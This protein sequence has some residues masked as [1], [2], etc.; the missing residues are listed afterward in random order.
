MNL[1]SRIFVTCERRSEL[2][3][4]VYANICLGLATVAAIGFGAYN[5]IQFGTMITLAR[6]AMI[7]TIV[8]PLALQ[9]GLNS[10][11][12][13][14]AGMIFYGYS[15]ALGLMIAPLLHTVSSQQLIL[16][17]LL[18]GG[19]VW[20]G[21]HLARN[22]DFGNGEAKYLNIGLLVLIAMS[23]IN[24]FLKL[25]MV[26]LLISVAGMALFVGIIGYEISEF[27]QE[28]VRFG[29]N[30]NKLAMVISLRVVCSIVNLFVY[31]LR[32]LRIT[33]TGRDRD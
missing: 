30:L 19:L 18:T 24:L 2:V 7:P 4:K 32:F 1:V 10:M 25:T 3:S 22:V 17:L 23:I 27:E 14:T 21:L 13:A 11:S 8:L 12:E 33:G 9:I 5:L 29:L 15:A 26:E 20:L 6:L 16:A 31:A 28:N